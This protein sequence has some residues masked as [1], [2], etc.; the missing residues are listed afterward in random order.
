MTE[1]GFY[2]LPPA[3]PDLPA[4]ASKEK[5]AA[6]E[7]TGDLYIDTGP[8]LPESY[9]LDMIRLL[10]QDPYRVYVFWELT[11]TGLARARRRGSLLGFNDGQTVVMVTRPR[12]ASR[13]PIEVG[14][15]RDWWLV[16]DPDTEYRAEIGVMFGD[17]FFTIAASNKVRTPRVTV[18][19]ADVPVQLL[20]AG[21]EKKQADLIRASGYEPVTAGQVRE[22]IRERRAL[23]PRERTFIDQL[24]ADLRET[25][26]AESPKLLPES[27]RRIVLALPRFIMLGSERVM[28]PQSL[29]EW[30]AWPAVPG[31]WPTSP[32]KGV[33]NAL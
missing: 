12:D 7:A 11:E 25:V 8:A 1:R 4:P 29:L 33:G 22:R 26:F 27:L 23:T 32:T 3:Q 20:P 2:P 30:L 24:P 10:V 18:A 9:D 28:I 15:S 5:P 16:A 6:S 21:E 17:H 13:M 14:G 31:E 19:E